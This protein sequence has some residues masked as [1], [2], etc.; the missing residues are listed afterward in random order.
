[1]MNKDKQMLSVDSIIQ[2]QGKMHWERSLSGNKNGK[3][4]DIFL[5]KNI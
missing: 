1:M 2:A 4:F 3:C 5:I